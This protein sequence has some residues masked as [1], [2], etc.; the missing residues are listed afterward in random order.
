MSPLCLQHGKMVIGNLS[1]YLWRQCVILWSRRWL[2]A[3]VVNAGFK[4]WCLCDPLYDQFAHIW[5]ESEYM[6]NFFIFCFDHIMTN[7][8]I[9]TCHSIIWLICSYIIRELPQPSTSYY[10]HDTHV[11]MSLWPYI[12]P[13]WPI[14]LYM[15]WIL[16]WS[17]YSYFVLTIFIMKIFFIILTFTTW[18]TFFACLCDPVSPGCHPGRGIPRRGCVVIVKVKS[19]VLVGNRP[20]TYCS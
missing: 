1:R 10:C 5:Y 16:L 12:C 2:K 14:C 8:F 15:V 9:C 20:C 6:T 17:I 13:I 19:T 7:F 4:T 11:C 18:Y 3:K